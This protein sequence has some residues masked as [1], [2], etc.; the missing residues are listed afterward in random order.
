MLIKLPGASKAHPTGFGTLPAVIC[1]GFDQ[2][3]LEG[4]KAGQNCDQQLALRGR[5][6]APRIVQRFKLGA[7]LGELVQDI[8]QIAG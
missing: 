8:E 7:L 6:I 3:P 1:A 5:G 4:G 2:V